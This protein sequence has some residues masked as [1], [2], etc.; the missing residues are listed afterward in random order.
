MSDELDLTSFRGKGLQ[1]GEVELPEG[2]G[3][4]APGMWINWHEWWTT[5]FDVIRWNIWQN[6]KKRATH[7]ERKTKNKP[8]KNL[9]KTIQT[10]TKHT[11][12]HPKQE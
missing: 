2:D 6:Y 9:N 11:K 8:T 3:P 5:R 4:P 10:T 12:K 1:A 7:Q